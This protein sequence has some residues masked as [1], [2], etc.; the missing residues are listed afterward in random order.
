[1]AQVH[2]LRGHDVFAAVGD[3]TRRA[4]LDMLRHGELG[5][6]EI[7]RPFRMSRPAIS[8][9]LKVL[10][11]AGLVTVRRQGREQIYALRPEPLR[12]VYDWVEHYRAFWSGKLE[13]L[14]AFLREKDDS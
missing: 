9:H 14:G 13:A 10:K 5:A 6:G 7:G 11:R 2:R 1:M 3:P 4:M 8:Q 12:G